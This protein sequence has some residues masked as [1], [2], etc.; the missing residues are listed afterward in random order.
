M[1]NQPPSIIAALDVGTSK[2]A[3]LIAEK[4]ANGALSYRGLGVCPVRGVLAM[5]GVRDLDGVEQAIRTAVSK[6]E[7][8][9]GLRV[10]EVYVSMRGG[11][12][13]SEVVEAE[14][15]T[16]GRAVTADDII[17]VNAA[18]QMK[19]E[20][21]KGRVTLH[22]LPVGYIFNGDFDAKPPIDL[23][24][25]TLGASLLV[26]SVNEG[27]Y[28]NL[29]MA[30][31]RAQLD[32]AAII[33]A[34]YASA[35]ATITDDEAWTG[36]AIIDM[37][38]GLTDISFYFRSSIMHTAQITIG[39]DEI[40]QAVMGKFQSNRDGAERLKLRSGAVICDTTDTHRR[41]DVVTASGEEHS[42]PLSELTQLL[43]NLYSQRLDAIGEILDRVGFQGESGDQLVF[44]GGGAQA[45]RLEDLAE[46]RL[47]RS[48][49]IGDPVIIGGM[50]ENAQTASY[51]CLVGLAMIGAEQPAERQRS[52]ARQKKPSGP[53]GRFVEWLRETF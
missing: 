7:R 12:P 32:V 11:D 37:G 30:V 24:G 44:T 3:C 20:G 21:Q 26:F 34:G 47:G 19:Y 16:K 23:F 43:E 40:T 1:T 5:G 33:Y 42:A 27:A 35:R 36:T 13:R 15:D 45:R 52:N 41:M 46:K 28:K 4:Q 8:L 2:V 14:I 31:R 22:A 53:L 9:A 38:A 49:R 10:S 29:E 48:A 50:P 39:T 18:A 6:A 17:A 25:D 51:A